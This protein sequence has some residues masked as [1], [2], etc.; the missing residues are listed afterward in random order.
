MRLFLNEF[1]GDS[2]PGCQIP[3]EASRRV[4]SL[5]LS[6][7]LPSALEGAASEFGPDATTITRFARRL[8]AGPVEITLSRDA[9]Y[10]H[11][12]ADLLHLRHPLVRFAV[13][14]TDKDRARLQRAFALA[15]DRS[16]VLPPGLYVFGISLIEIPGYRPVNKLMAVVVDLIGNR[17]WSDPEETTPVVL[18]LLERAEDH[19]LP[20][21]DLTLLGE[22]KGRAVTALNA[23]LA[24]WSN[25]EQRLDFVRREQQHTALRTTLEFRLQRA[26]L[27]LAALGARQ[28]A[29]FALRM[30]QAQVTK[31]RQQLDATSAPAS[32]AWPGLEHEEIAVGT[33]KVGA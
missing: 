22:A 7:G 32:L 16:K 13:A 3:E 4:V 15:L 23:L 31:A 11:P 9:G 33:L 29:D 10:R 14:E 20:A 26:N 25:R 6:D 30:A 8:S 17:T 5:H 19:Q 24:D 28:A 2:F 18:E 27:R 21:F 1:L 12:R